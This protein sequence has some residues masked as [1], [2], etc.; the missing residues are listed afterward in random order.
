ML[1]RVTRE[2]VELLAA[3]ALERRG[4]TVAFT[5]RS[6]AAGPREFSGMNLSFDVGDDHRA[7]TSSRT[8]LA[9]ALGVDPGRMVF[10][11]QVHGATVRVVG[12]LDVGRGAADHD[13]GIPRADGLVS[14]LR[15]VAVG[16]LT[17]DCLPVVLAAP[18]ARAVAVAHAGWRGVL[19]GTAEAALRKLLRETGCAP[20]E[21]L[22]FIGPHI[23]PCCFETGP[24]VTDLFERR[25]G[26]AR[27]S[28]ARGR[29]DLGRA[30]AGRLV[31]AGVPHGRV[32]VHEECT[33]CGRDY[34][35]YRASGGACGRQ[36]GFAVV[37]EG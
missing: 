37:A 28:G 26:S 27:F 1:E 11:R 29:I 19:A 24:E 7:V 22:A 33:S 35:S 25:I 20:V 21:V 17:A 15:G 30:C 36:G 32:H 8:A 13:S 23:R 3:P 31:A 12:P 4:I 14:M 9:A 16:V 6:Q 5:G 18:S 10:P 34:F 2:G